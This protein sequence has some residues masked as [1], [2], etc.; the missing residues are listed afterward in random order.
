[1]ASVEEMKEALDAQR[2]QAAHVTDRALSAIDS[3]V[4]IS[5]HTLTF[6]EIFITVLT[7]V[8]VGVL[9]ASTRW[10]ATKVAHGRINAYIKSTEGYALIRQAVQDEVRNQLESKVVVQF[11]PEEAANGDGHFPSAPGQGEGP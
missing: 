3:V 11:R 9:I 7:L 10:F 2:D 6:V 8:G 4:A 5:A 1:M